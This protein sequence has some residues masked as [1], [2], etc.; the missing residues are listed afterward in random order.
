V[1]AGTRIPI[2]A[3]KDFHAAGYSTDQII[4]E[5]PDLT[6]EDVEAALAHKAKDAA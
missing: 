5:Y 3:V 4:K 1:I 2:N 6:A